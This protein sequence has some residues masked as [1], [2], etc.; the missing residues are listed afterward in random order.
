MVVRHLKQ[1][2]VLNHR[3]NNLPCFSFLFPENS[4]D[5]PYCPCCLFFLVSNQRLVLM[6]GRYQQRLTAAQISR[7][8]GLFELYVITSEFENNKKKENLIIIKRRTSYLLG[9][10]TNLKETIKYQMKNEY[11]VSAITS[12]IK[13]NNIHIRMLINIIPQTKRQIY[14]SIRSHFWIITF[15]C[16]MCSSIIISLASLGCHLTVARDISFQNL[17]AIFG[18]RTLG[19][20]FW[21]SG[22]D[23]PLLLDSF[24]RSASGFQEAVQKSQLLQ[25]MKFCFSETVPSAKSVAV[26]EPKEDCR[27]FV[28][29][30]LKINK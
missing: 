24:A 15:R 25:S 12:S 10:Y 19:N 7:C 30:T 11:D 17:M 14:S 4:T 9:K 18:S 5:H 1:F 6:V 26:F 23:V 21:L 29:F 2:S 13:N 16:F 28:Y 22:S 20:V 27:V 8:T 3:F